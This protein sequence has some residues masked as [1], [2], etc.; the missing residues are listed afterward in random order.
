[1]KDKRDEAFTMVKQNTYKIV[2]LA[3]AHKHQGMKHLRSKGDNSIA[4]TI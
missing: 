2:I 3:H 1:M 4:K